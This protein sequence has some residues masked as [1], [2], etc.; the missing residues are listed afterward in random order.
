MVRWKQNESE[1]I[2]GPQDSA[3]TIHSRQ[4]S[5]FDESPVSR[6]GYAKIFWP[7]PVALVYL[8]RVVPEKTTSKNTDKLPGATFLSKRGWQKT[9]GST[10][11][12]ARG[13]TQA[14]RKLPFCPKVK[15]WTAHSDCCSTDGGLELWRLCTTYTRGMCCLIS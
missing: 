3:D 10:T 6:V 1:E 12:A 8:R 4:L 14:S 13:K 7:S 5:G 9:L 11:V 15:L 2:G